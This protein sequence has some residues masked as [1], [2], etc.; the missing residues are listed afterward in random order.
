MDY[1]LLV[2]PN[3]DEELMLDEGEDGSSKVRVRLYEVDGLA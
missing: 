3:P 2:P 1:L